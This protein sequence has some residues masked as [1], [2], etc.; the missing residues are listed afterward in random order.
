MYNAKVT[1][2]KYNELDFRFDSMEAL[3]IFVDTVFNTSEHDDIEITIKKEVSV[4]AET[5]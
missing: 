1:G 4:D 2:N 3:G 5:L